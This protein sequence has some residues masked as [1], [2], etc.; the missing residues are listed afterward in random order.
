[1]IV[2]S[3][4]KDSLRFLTFDIIK[5][6][7]EDPETHTLTSTRSL[8]AGMSAGVVASTFSVTPTERIKTALI[9]DARN[10]ASARKY[11]GPVQ[12]TMLIWRER[13]IRGLWSGYV[14]TTLKQAGATSVRL[15]SYNII[16]DWEKER[17]WQPSIALN[18][19]NGMVAGT[20]TTLLTQPVDTLKTRAQGVAS[21]KIMVAVEEI[22]R[23]NGIRGFWSGTVMRL[24]RTVLSGGVLFTT[25]EFMSDLLRPLFTTK[26]EA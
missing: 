3:F 23:T 14:A 19:F 20:T 10:P 16:K 18:F 8:L 6:A 4:A 7:F 1:M 21:Q 24:G 26:V 9:D 22:W 5:S 15:G 12:C 2:G 25:N 17:G 11:T 13:G